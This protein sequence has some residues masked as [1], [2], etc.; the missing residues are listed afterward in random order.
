MNCHGRKLLL[1]GNHDYWWSTVTSMRKYLKENDF[2][3][4][5]KY[6]IDLGSKYNYE[7]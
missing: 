3:E 4:L 6:V 2:D 7:L 1:K 5:W